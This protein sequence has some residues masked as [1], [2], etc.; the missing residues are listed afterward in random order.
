M[1]A[2]NRIDGAPR[3]VIV[4]GAGIVGL[5]VAWFL[6]ERGVEVTLVDRVGVA[7][8]SSWGNAGWIS[9]ALAI[10]LNEPANL[11]FGLR[12]LFSR[13]A[14]LQVP[15]KSGPAL[16]A[17]LARFATNSRPAA[18]RRAV[19]ANAPLSAECIEAYDVLLANGVDAPVTNAPFTA[20]FRTSADAERW[21]EGLRRFSEAGQPVF[22]TELTGAALAERV[23]L[24]SA[25]V[26]AGV[27]I[28]GQRFL[29]PGRFVSALGR[30]VVER[31]AALHVL[32]VTDV[33]PSGDAVTV[34]ARDGTTLTAAAAVIAS[35]AWL[36]RLA[37]RWVRVPVRAGRGYSFSVPVDKPVTGPIYLPEA[38][39]ACTPLN[40]RLRVAGTMEFGDP[41]SPVVPVRV[42]A[43]VAAARPL[44]DG[45]R[46][47][48]RTDVWVGPRPVSPDGR[49]LVGEVCP[50][51]VY[52]AG[53]HGMWGMTHGPVTGR[54]LAEQITTG[55][56]SAVL[57]DLDPLR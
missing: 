40:A 12:S 27:Q 5:S 20:I 26:A 35:G 37:A 31:G 10:P 55:K 1:D 8:G 3:S 53:G 51:S 16:W 6:Q 30:A 41:D 23:P 48:E 13:T 14:A 50:R 42:E 34:T 7:A 24:A 17:F 22:S 33:S 46:W 11:R 18:W 44:L 25:A 49:P 43:I 4:V 54:L 29:D 38:R 36:S 56:Q 52:V 57:R 15:L 45:V 2:A 28:D 47:D 9:P 32:D 21:L 19:R 39:V